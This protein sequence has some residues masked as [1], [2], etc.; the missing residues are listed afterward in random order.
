MKASEKNRLIALLKGYRDK[1]DEMLN[2]SIDLVSELLEDMAED[3]NL[4]NKYLSLVSSLNKA[5]SAYVSSLA[6]EYSQSIRLLGS[7]EVTND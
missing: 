1:G 4:K 7:I 2:L 3:E 5:Q 6:D